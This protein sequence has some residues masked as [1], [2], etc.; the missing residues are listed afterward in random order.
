MVIVE[1]LDEHGNKVDQKQGNNFEQHHVKRPGK[2]YDISV[3]T[4]IKINQENN[5]YWS[6]L[7]NKEIDFEIGEIDVAYVTASDTGL[8]RNQ[9]LSSLFLNPPVVVDAYAGVGMDSIS[10]LYNLYWKDGHTIKRLYVVENGGEEEKERNDR[11]ISNVQKFVAARDMQ[12]EGLVEFCLWGTENFFKECKNFKKNPVNFIDLLYLDPPW[13]V[14]GRKNSGKKGEATPQELM[15][16]VYDTILKVLIDQK[17]HV[18]VVCIKTR[19][20]WREVSNII[21]L[22]REKIKDPKK[23]FLHH[24]TIK[25]KPFENVYYFHS[26]CTMEPEV[27]EWVETAVFE[28][29]YHRLRRIRNKQKNRSVNYQ[30]QYDRDLVLLDPQRKRR[31]DLNAIVG[32]LHERIS[33]LELQEANANI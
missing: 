2:E 15:D 6:Y 16:Y 19:F 12:T 17:I 7:L 30:H 32:A 26:I 31:R 28:K 11:L 8:I 13:T 25:C 3:D 18:R 27:G 21:E 20:E 5:D 24:S 14:P 1:F 22:L 29:A 9:Y 10:F 23:Q 33:Q 4:L